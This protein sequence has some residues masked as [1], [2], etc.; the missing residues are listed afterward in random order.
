MCDVA[1]HSKHIF[2]W[3]GPEVGVVKVGVKLQNVKCVNSSLAS[4][5]STLLGH[6]HYFVVVTSHVENKH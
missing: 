6:S 5:S 2:K 4:D 3:S 1:S